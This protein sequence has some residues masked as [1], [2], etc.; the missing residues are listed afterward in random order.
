MPRR[1][2]GGGM[3]GKKRSM[4]SSP[5]PAS[6]APPPAVPQRQGGG[7]GFLGTMMQGFALG[8]G[9]AVAHEA[10]HGAVRSFSAGCGTN[11][12]FRGLWSAAKGFPRLHASKQW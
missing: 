1:R 12:S 7:G 6:K 10:I 4:F 9:S 3:G 2:G 5:A 11:G 8:T